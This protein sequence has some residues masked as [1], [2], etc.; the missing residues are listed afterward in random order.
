[1]YDLN[2]RFLGRGAGT[3]VEAKPKLNLDIGL[4]LGVLINV[5]I[6]LG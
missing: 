6:N 4:D 3:Y 2:Q 1:M 5:D